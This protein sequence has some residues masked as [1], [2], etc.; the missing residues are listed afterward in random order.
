MSEYERAWLGPDI[1]A[2]ITLAAVAI[3]ECMGYTKIV[4]TPVVT[5]LYT[6][7]LPIVAFAIFGSSRHLV[8]GADSATAAILFAGLTGLAQPYSREWLTLTSVAALLTAAF[9]FLARIVRLGFLANFLS[10]TVLVGFLS[11]VGI[12]LLVGQL[13]DMLGVSV[14]SQ[15]FLPRL[16]GSLQALPQ[17]HLPTLVMALAMLAVMLLTERFIPKVPGTLLAVALAIGATW[18]FRLDQHGIA[19]VGTVQAGLPAFGLPRVPIG[20][21]LRLIATSASMFLVIVAQSAATSRSFAQQHDE[22]FSENR[23]LVGLG[24]ANAL[25]G[26][27]NTFVVNGSPTK[28][29][30]VA[31][32]GGRTQVA[33]LVTAAVTLAVL[34][35]ATALIE[36]LPNAA[37]AAIVFLIGLRLIDVRD[38]RQIYR[39]RK[40]TFA[41]AI[42]TLL[43]VVFL[44][45]ER[46]IFLAIG[47]SILDHLR[48]EYNPKDDVIVQAGEHWKPQK[49][50]PGME[51]EPGLLVYRF[52]APLFFANVDYFSARL[53]LLLKS[54]PHPVKWLV[55]DLVSTADIDYTAGLTFIALLKRFQHM[56]ITVA[57]AQDEDIRGELDRYAITQQVGSEHL[58]DT[59]QAAVQAYQEQAGVPP[60]VTGR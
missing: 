41:V 24:L 57:L 5:G 49:A 58:F 26:L 17:T 59:V 45:V 2:G 34:L 3:P 37:L 13:P 22:P 25:A 6:I 54:A 20:S 12:S 10:R 1:V 46:G 19:V 48:Q 42:G 56:G 16:L 36:W 4:G 11:G 32:A 40:P 14:G 8:V 9:L 51:T 50:A 60:V 7:L 53:Q 23:D 28:T 38:L 39:L 47:L 31:A 27:S 29:A 55:L 33:Q 18:I 35:F 52:E 15:A 44:G 30:V 43:G 21:V